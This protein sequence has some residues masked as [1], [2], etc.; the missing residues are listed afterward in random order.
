M[1]SF[2]GFGVWINEI[3]EPF[4]LPTAYFNEPMSLYSD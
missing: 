2:D 4:S 3:D 1:I